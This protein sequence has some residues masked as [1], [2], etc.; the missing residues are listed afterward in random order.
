[1][2][3]VQSRGRPG[4]RVRVDDPT[5]SVGLKA[6]DEQ[7]RPPILVSIDEIWAMRLALLARPLTCC[8]HPYVA[9]ESLQVCG[10]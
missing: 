8:L 7:L 4:K 1:M 6:A 10:L 5:V 9:T 3:P 2:P